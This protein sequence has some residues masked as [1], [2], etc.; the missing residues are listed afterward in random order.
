MTA[1]PSKCLL[2]SLSLSLAG[3]LSACGGEP[4]PATPAPV[5]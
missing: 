4:R 5:V 3:L 1:F 2:L